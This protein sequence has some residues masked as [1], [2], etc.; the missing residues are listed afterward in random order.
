MYKSKNTSKN[1]RSL[2]FLAFFSPKLKTQQESFFFFHRWPKR[3]KESAFSPSR[4]LSILTTQILSPLSSGSLSPTYDCELS[5]ILFT[6]SFF[7]SYDLINLYLI[8]GL[9]FFLILKFLISTCLTVLGYSNPC[10]IL[11]L[12]LIKF[13]SRHLCFK[14]L[15]S[16]AQFQFDVGTNQSHKNK[17]ALRKKSHNQSHQQ[18]AEFDTTQF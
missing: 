12:L 7:K 15:L 11:G 4:T 8:L 5:S 6:L 18:I 9:S 10:K 14:I 1:K 13:Q 3:E 17:M 2:F 16:M